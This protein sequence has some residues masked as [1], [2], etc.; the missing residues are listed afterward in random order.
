MKSKKLDNIVI[1]DGKPM[2]TKDWETLQKTKKDIVKKYFAIIA[3]SKVFNFGRQ[4]DETIYILSVQYNI[5][6]RQPFRVYTDNCFITDCN[7]LDT[8]FIDGDHKL[9]TV[10][11]MR[12]SKFDYFISN[13]VRDCVVFKNSGGYD[14][15]DIDKTIEEINK[16]FHEIKLTLEESC[17]AIEFQYKHSNISHYNMIVDS[18]CDEYGDPKEDWGYYLE[19]DVRKYLSILNEK[20]KNKNK[21]QKLKKLKEYILVEA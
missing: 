2:W 17:N 21:V 8:E 20:E 3:P 15:T 7:L 9:S 13:E 6:E 14:I 10:N 16:R 12:S 11:L 5:Y 18:G 4:K 19:E 1:V